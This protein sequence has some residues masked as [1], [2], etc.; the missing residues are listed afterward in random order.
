MGD[1]LAECDFCFFSGVTLV[2]QNTIARQRSKI[3][4]SLLQLALVFCDEYGTSRE[5]D[6]IT[7][8]QALRSNVFFKWES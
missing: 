4:K 6:H 7:R 5:I 8:E 3:L 1:G 2:A